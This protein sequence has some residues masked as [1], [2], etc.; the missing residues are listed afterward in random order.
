[1]NTKDTM[2]SIGVDVSK[3]HLD[4]AVYPDAAVRRFGNDGAG[5][6]A[7]LD[8]LSAWPVD[9]VVMEATGRLHELA[10]GMLT[11]E[12]FAVAVVNPARVRYFA[13]AK[14]R[15]AKTDRIDALV[16]AEYGA[17][18]RPVP[19]TPVDE[20]TRT[21]RQLVVRRRQLV[22]LRAVETN[23]LNSRIEDTLDGLIGES[24][25][26]TL[27]VLSAQIT[28][29]ERRIDD[30]IQACQGLRKADGV[31]R[32]MPGVGPVLSQ[33]ILA[34]MPEIG[35]LTRK[36]IA[37]LAGV[38]PINRDSGAFRG[39]RAIHGGRAYVRTVL[40]MATVAAIRCNPVVK[41][42]YTALKQAGKPTKVAITACMRKIIVMLNAMVR[43][44]KEWKMN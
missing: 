42:T 35:Q 30:H 19:R 8:W 15:L 39:R 36:Q 6:V 32:T 20:I 12:G 41:H 17:V 1:M 16:L 9:L 26:A 31:M 3:R 44:Q 24:F 22:E 7:C 18:M 10:A 11:A 34:E 14:G 28:T 37:S 25:E 4:V 29:V 33:T 27:L 43:D 21:L 40:Y 2:V 23:R 13:R 5:L 38:A